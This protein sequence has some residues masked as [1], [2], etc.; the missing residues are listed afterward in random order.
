MAIAVA[1]N[2]ALVRLA[3]AIAIVALPAAG[4][5]S[6]AELSE[7]PIPRFVHQNGR[8]AL[9]VDGKPFLILAAQV[10]NSSNY[11]AMLPRVWPAIEQLH[12]NTVQVPVAWEQIEPRE[13]QFD[14]SFLDALLPQAREHHVRLILLWF[15]AW[16]NNNLM[17]TPEWVKLD[18]SRYPRVV[19]PKGE[20][21]GS[22]SPLGEATLAADR[23][24]FAALMRHLR[25]VDAQR[26][27]IMVQV[28][29]E[30]GTYGS[31][32]DF[33]PRAQKL[34]A[35]AVP[36]K[37]TRALKKQPGA[38]KQVLGEDADEYFHAWH[39][40]SFVEQVAAAGKAEYALPLY[41]NAAL[42]DPLKPSSPTTYSS[43]GPTDNVLDVWKAAAP[44]IDLIAPDIY[45]PDYPRYTR[46]LELYARADNPLFV[47]ETGNAASFAPYV[48][49]TLGRQGIGF[50]PF[51]MDFTGYSNYPLGARKLDDES[52]RPF[53][54]SYQLLATMAG[55][56]A[57]LSFE[58]K[59]YGV[60]ENPAEHR[61]I[62]LIPGRWKVSVAYGLNQFGNDEPPGNR[63]P[64]GGA[65]VARLGADEF[66]VTG[67]LARVE[68]GVADAGSGQKLQFLRVEEG[69]Y[70]DGEWRFIR[71]W[72]GD[73]IDWGL[74]FTSAPQ[75]LRVRL[76][77]Y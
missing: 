41:V 27:V 53:A 36:A 77:S 71:V 66:L 24:A 70:R 42:R 63:E 26:T 39:I 2:L 50:S 14:F 37:L 1:A 10:N 12:A 13:G 30:T 64:M 23:K 21:M 25:S 4:I 18:N 60:S 35:G 6:A 28:E 47:A 74:N 49:A 69:E 46:V 62:L 29:N 73:Q 65:L 32:R 34:F 54:A 59:V 20:R 45:M 76:A 17:Y 33:S 72:N 31:V 38:W 43:G 57:R 7:A 15:G 75:V 58:G 16:K 51:G 22:L 48:F 67:C 9:L 5:A 61:Q 40:A 44:S 19:N 55:E 3:T 68:F 56:I 11:P 8:H 52:L